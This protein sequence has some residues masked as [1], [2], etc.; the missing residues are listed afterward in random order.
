M[1]YR[2]EYGFEVS[3]YG[4]TELEAED[5]AALEQLTRELDACDNLCRDG[6]PFPDLG[7][8][9]HRVVRVERLDE[10]G[11]WR[12]VDEQGYD[13]EPEPAERDSPPIAYDLAQLADLGRAV[14]AE[15]LDSSEQRLVE[16]DPL[17]NDTELSEGDDGVWVRAW[18]L[19]PKARLEEAGVWPGDSVAAA[20]EDDAADDDTFFDYLESSETDYRMEA[21]E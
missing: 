11:N 5:L 4:S 7:T 16:I 6:K 21:E 19:V 18:V 8:A 3:A 14:L 15:I 9:N 17:L 20:D 12:V 2:V 1:R 10:D 13:L